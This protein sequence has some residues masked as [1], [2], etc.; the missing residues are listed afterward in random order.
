MV[1]ILFFQIA[2]KMTEIDLIKC[3]DHQLLAHNSNYLADMRILYAIYD[4]ISARDAFGLQ[5]LLSNLPEIT[6][7]KLINSVRRAISP[8][9][10]AIAGGSAEIVRILIKIGR[11]DVNQLT[12]DVGRQRIETPLLCAVRLQRFEIAR[13]LIDAGADVNAADWCDF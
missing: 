10:M 11:V 8:L 4:R 1:Y 6:K 5:T 7:I 12:S 13:Q 2:A 3:D 9:A